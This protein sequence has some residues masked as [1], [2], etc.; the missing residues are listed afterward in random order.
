MRRMKT[1][2]ISK[3]SLLLLCLEASLPRFLCFYWTDDEENAR[4]KSQE[5]YAH[6][7]LEVGA[8]SVVWALSAMSMSKCNIA[9]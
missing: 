5:C 3:T 6:L 9:F 2:R 1:D 4:T 8:I 7:P